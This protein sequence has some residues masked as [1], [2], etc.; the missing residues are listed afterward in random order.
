MTC[1]SCGSA[2]DPGGQFCGNC[3]TPVARLPSRG[4][5][6]LQLALAGGMVLAAVAAAGLFAFSSVLFGT[7]FRAAAFMPRDTWFVAA[8]TVRPGLVQQMRTTSILEAFTKQPGFADTML[9]LQSSATRTDVNWEEEVVPLLEGE[10]AI[11]VYGPT[12]DPQGLLFIRSND[13]EG[14]LRLLAVASE[15]PEPRDRYKDGLYYVTLS[16]GREIQIIASP[17]GWIVGG[18]SRT[19]TEQAYDRLET[20]SGESL[21]TD[22]RYRSVIERLPADRLGYAYW[23]GRVLFTDPITRRSFDLLP[24]QVRDYFEPLNARMALSVN[25]AEEGIELQWESIPERATDQRSD[26]PSGNALSALDRLPSDTL[27]AIGGHSL[28]T[29]LSG[30]DTAANEYLGSALGPLAPRIEFDFSQWLGGEFALGL[31]RGDLRSGTTLGSPDV[32]FAAKLKDPAAAASDLD[33]FDFLLSPKNRSVQGYMLKEVATGSVSVTYGVGGDWLYAAVGATDHLLPA[34]NGRTDGLTTATNFG[35]VK[36]A[37]RE[38]GFAIYVDLENGRRLMEDLLPASSRFEYDEKA[39][40]LLQPFRALGGSVRTDPNGD[41]H[42]SLL[43]A[44]RR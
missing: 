41:V 3:G 30:L 7:G 43:I 32:L 24:R 11:G 33:A 12:S 29:M 44:I 5:S 4:R 42:G 6:G 28:P 23:D 26:L 14:L 35:L 17:K 20:E 34:K 37:I 25:T 1:A 36:R 27:V 40:V 31:G 18:T 13:P 38:D 22:A 2:L 9:A 10:I 16:G 8:M 39:R 15:E 21:A 19:A